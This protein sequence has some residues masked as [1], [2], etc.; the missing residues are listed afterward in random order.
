MFKSSLEYDIKIL[1]TICGYRI[2]W[3]IIFYITQNKKLFKELNFRK[4][5]KSINT[6]TLRM[7]HRAT[8]HSQKFRSKILLN[9]VNI[10]GVIEYNYK[11]NI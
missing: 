9:S 6:S 2:K 4:E 11:K 3:K 10:F 7:V 1:L 8:E 5:I